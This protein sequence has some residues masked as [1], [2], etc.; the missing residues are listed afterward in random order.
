MSTC[1]H[2]GGEGQ[3]F[4]LISPYWSDPSNSQAQRATSGTRHGLAHQFVFFLSLALLKRN[5]MILELK[6]VMVNV[7]CITLFTLFDSLKYCLFLLYFV[8]H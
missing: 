2:L 4:E 7:L 1:H 8:R 5:F 3:P 6:L